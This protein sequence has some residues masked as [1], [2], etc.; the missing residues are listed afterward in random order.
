MAEVESAAALAL[1]DVF[2]TFVSKNAPG[3]RY[4]AVR[5]VTLTVGDGQAAFYFSLNS[6][7]IEFQG[8][9]FPNDFLQIQ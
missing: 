8:V 1:Q 6:Y 3:Q 2:C 9:Y 5:D 4:T 7:E